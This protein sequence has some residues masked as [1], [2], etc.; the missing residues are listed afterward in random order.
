ME[1]P[2]A[3]LNSTLLRMFPLTHMTIK[4]SDREALVQHGL[5]TREQ[6]LR[7]ECN[8]RETAALTNVSEITRVKLLNGERST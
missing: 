7:F 8:T 6:L 5:V 4:E 1:N 2:R 3:K